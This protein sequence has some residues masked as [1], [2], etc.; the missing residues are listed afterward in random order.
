MGG[1][2]ESLRRG[3]E[4]NSR[5]VK[6]GHVYLALKSMICSLLY[7]R[8]TSYFHCFDIFITF[9]MYYNLINNSE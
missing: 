1:P 4:K 6:W 2:N 5:I 7:F 3:L 9:P 8:A